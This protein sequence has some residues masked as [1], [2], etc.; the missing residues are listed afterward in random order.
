MSEDEE[1]VVL[2][3]LHSAKGLE[4]DN[5]YMSGL[6][7]GLFPSFLSL[8]ADDPE[9]EIEE[10]RR[11]FYVGVTRAK[12]RLTITAAKSRM[13]QGE[14][15][16]SAISRFIK[17]IPKDMLEG[18]AYDERRSGSLLEE[19]SSGSMAFSSRNSAQ[20]KNR[21]RQFE[22]RDM[23]LES[24]LAPTRKI[25][26]KPLDYSVG[27]RVTHQKFGEGEVISVTDGGRDFEV[28]VRFNEGKVRKMFASF[29]NLTKV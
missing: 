13:V 5:V 19:R 24:S 16:Y 17:E 23:D 8:V 20:S 3:T 7:D 2:M 29:A 28:A 27:D 11:L 21:T 14:T 18:T 1:Y 25:E 10:E 9:E 12:R 6:E 26:K 22:R 15:R 4:F